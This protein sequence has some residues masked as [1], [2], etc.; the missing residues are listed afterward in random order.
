[1][2]VLALADGCVHHGLCYRSAAEAERSGSLSGG[3][4]LRD[5]LGRQ[6]PA[7]PDQAAAPLTAPLHSPTYPDGGCIPDTVPA[8]PRAP[9][10]WQP[11]LLGLN[12]F[13]AGHGAVEAALRQRRIR[14]H[15]TG[16]LIEGLVRHWA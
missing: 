10:A 2:S 7:Q 11:P 12:P 16:C 14:A 8:N 4:A 3:G 1:M 6:A 9:H 13:T 5:H 15:A